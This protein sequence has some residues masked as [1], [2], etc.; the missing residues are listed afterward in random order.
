[1]GDKMSVEQIKA[2]K[3]FET[4]HRDPHLKMKL[5]ANPKEVAKE[6]GVKL[7]DHVVERLKNLG[8]FIALADE[9]VSGKVFR[10]FPPEVCYPPLVWQKNATLE[11]VRD[12]FFDRPFIIKKDWVFYPPDVLT[13]VEAKID[14]NLNLDKGRL[15]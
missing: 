9:A 2:Q 13:R 8:A 7:E 1:M 5:L 12:L 4:A 15:G 10:C 6:W 3:L 11:L 14:K